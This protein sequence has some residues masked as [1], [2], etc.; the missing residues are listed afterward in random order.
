MLGLTG[1]HTPRHAKAYR[2]FA[3]DCA[4]L[5]RDRI[6]AYKEFTADVN[7]GAYPAPYHGVPIDDSAFTTFVA[8][9]GA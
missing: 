5:Q 8:G 6:A 4:R 2:N 7:T 9:L 1:G 3:A